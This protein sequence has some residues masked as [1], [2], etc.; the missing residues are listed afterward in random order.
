VLIVPSV[1]REYLHVP[2]SGATADE[3]VELAVIDEG[4]EE[5]AEGDWMPADVW[6]GT[7]AKLLIG[8][9]G[10]LDL[11]DGTYRVWVRVTALPEVPVIRSGLLRIT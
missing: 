5:P 7:T 2:V 6:D 11:V 1:S 4:A 3:P 9:G 10:T 8:P